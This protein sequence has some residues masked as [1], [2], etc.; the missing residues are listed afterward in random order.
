M[1]GMAHL[2]ENEF[3]IAAI[4]NGKVDLGPERNDRTGSNLPPPKELLFV[5]N[6]KVREHVEGSC[7][8]FDESA[9]EYEIHVRGSTLN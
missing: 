4:A 8:R 7:K 5:I 3:T 9:A 6:E 1:D 2:R